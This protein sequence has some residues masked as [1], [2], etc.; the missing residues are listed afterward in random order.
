MAYRV[1]GIQSKRHTEERVVDIYRLN[2][3]HKGKF[4]IQ[5]LTMY[6]RY[7]IYFVIKSVIIW[8]TIYMTNFMI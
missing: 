3:I 2:S 5:M 8:I 4:Y 1:G 6:N 7:C